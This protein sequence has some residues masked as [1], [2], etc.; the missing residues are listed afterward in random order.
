MFYNWKK[1]RKFPTSTEY[2]NIKG[3]RVLEDVELW[4]KNESW[5]FKDFCNQRVGV[6]HRQFLGFIPF[7]L[8]SFLNFNSSDRNKQ[9]KFQNLLCF[10]E[11]FCLFHIV[12]LPLIN[13]FYQFCSHGTVFCTIKRRRMW[14]LCVELH[15][16]WKQFSWAK[17]ILH[18]CQQKT[19]LSQQMWC[20]PFPVPFLFPCLLLGVFCFRWSKQCLSQSANRKMWTYYRCDASRRCQMVLCQMVPRRGLHRD[21]CACS[22]Y[23]IWRKGSTLEL[24]PNFNP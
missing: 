20:S 19:S 3:I 12:L 2:C 5:G 8:H 9:K 21:N 1:L 18:S 6:S 10:F 13:Y 7:Y 23:A 16:F 22:S 24:Y 17:K 11:V 15:L 4:G 14:H